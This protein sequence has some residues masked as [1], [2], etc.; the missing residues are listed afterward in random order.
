MARSVE[1]GQGSAA[2]AGVAMDTA[3][4]TAAACAI[5]FMIERTCGWKVRGLHEAHRFSDQNRL[6]HGYRRGHQALGYDALKDSLKF[7]K[8][9]CHFVVSS[10]SRAAG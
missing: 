9:V 7:A 4:A 3:E 5:C 6:W 2:E 1:Y 10:T 8:H